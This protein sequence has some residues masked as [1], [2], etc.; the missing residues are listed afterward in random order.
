M[1]AQRDTCQIFH[2]FDFSSYDCRAQKRA[3]TK[4]YCMEVSLQ[5]LC[6]SLL[7][8]LDSRRLNQGSLCKFSRQAYH[9]IV[10]IQFDNIYMYTYTY[11]Y[12]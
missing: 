3:H 2:I 12:T 11:I 9:K 6:T 8:A 10:S 4:T 1:E 7:R 5:A